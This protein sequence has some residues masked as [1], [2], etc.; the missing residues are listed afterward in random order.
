[1][2]MG[3][4]GDINPM[5]A[6]YEVAGLKFGKGALSLSKKHI[7]LLFQTTECFRANQSTCYP[8]G[9]VFYAITR[10][11]LDMLFEV[12]PCPHIVRSVLACDLPTAVPFHREP[13]S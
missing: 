4:A 8:P 9:H 1:M 6:A 13:Y 5:A 3:R 7:T 12:M 10:N 2:F 11:G